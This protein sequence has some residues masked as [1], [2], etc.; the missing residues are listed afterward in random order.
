VPAPKHAVRVGEVSR[1]P[2]CARDGLL[3]N[4]LAFPS[5]G[6]LTPAPPVPACKAVRVREG[7]ARR[8][9]LT[10]ASR[11]RQPVIASRGDFPVPEGQSANRRVRGIRPNQEA[12]KRG[13]PQVSPFLSRAAGRHRPQPGR[14]SSIGPRDRGNR[15]SPAF[16]RPRVS[17][18]SSRLGKPRLASQRPSPG[19]I[20][21][22][23]CVDP[24]YGLIARLSAS[25]IRP[26]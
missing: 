20:S 15:R 21:S 6:T 2:P 10:A 7:R 23:L 16:P 18:L 14:L 19:K 12:W 4:D 17:R 22:A 3:A 11:R 26:A 1:G 9:D 25:S 8:G 13:R 5:H 24:F